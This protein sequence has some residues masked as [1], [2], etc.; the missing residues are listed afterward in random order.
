[1]NVNKQGIMSRI[2]NHYKST[3]NQIEKQAK[4]I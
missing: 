4:D 2:Y 1:M 3:R